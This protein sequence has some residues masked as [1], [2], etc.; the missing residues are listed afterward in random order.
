MI[1]TN[2]IRG[3]HFHNTKIFVPIVT[4][5]INYNI[6]FFQKLK[7]G[8]KRINTDQLLHAIGRN[9]R[10][11][12]ASIDNK[13]FFGE[14]IKKQTVILWKIV[15]MS[16]N[17]DHKTGILLDYLYHQKYYKL[18]DSSRQTNTNTPQ[19]IDFI[20]R[21]KENNRVTMVSVAE[22]QQKT[23]LNFSLDWLSTTK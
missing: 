8:L 23:N 2:G 15:K 6:K 7:S 11:F 19:H 16:R 1:E 3:V 18:I 5:S 4:L 10:V 22:K 9:E 17:N 20:G 13:P 14:P 12:F 21:L